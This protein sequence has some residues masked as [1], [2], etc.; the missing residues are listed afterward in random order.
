MKKECL[1]FIAICFLTSCLAEQDNPLLVASCTDEVR[2][3]NE[4]GIDCGGI[5][6]ACEEE[7]KP[8]VAPCKNNLQ[9]NRLTL[10]GIN[11]NLSSFEFGCY[12][13]SD[14]FEVHIYKDFQE[15]TI[16]VYESLLPEETKEIP[17]IPYYQA[18]DGYASIKLN[19]FY[20]YNSLRGFLYLS[21]KNNIT[22]IEFCSVDLVG[23]GITY[24]VSGR[25]VC[26]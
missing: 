14:H 10:N 5:C 8:A 12:Q 13:E 3:Q 6:G 16:E 26:D 17:L 7:E 4:E 22:T 11:K 2:N 20:N 24:E 19:D 9:N 1:Y 25:I 21:S 18:E 15:I 23:Q